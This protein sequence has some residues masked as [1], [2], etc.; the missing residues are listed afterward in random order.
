MNLLHPIVSAGIAATGF[1]HLQQ[2][3]ADASL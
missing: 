1:T 3:E 2:S